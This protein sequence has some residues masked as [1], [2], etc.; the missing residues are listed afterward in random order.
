[1]PGLGH[2]RSQLAQKL[3]FHQQSLSGALLDE[4]QQFG[5]RLSGKPETFE[6]EPVARIVY[7]DGKPRKLD[8]RVDGRR[9]DSGKP[10][11][12]GQGNETVADILMNVAVVERGRRLDGLVRLALQAC[13]GNI[14]AVSCRLGG[15]PGL[16]ENLD[17]GRGR[18]AQHLCDRHALR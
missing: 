14:S 2:G 1:M 15:E 13:P 11:E 16:V 5:W 3:V 8:Q 18:N 10:P 7:S 9:R 4:M 6:R 12:R 17:E